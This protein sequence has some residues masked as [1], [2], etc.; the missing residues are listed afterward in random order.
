M[1]E[2][3]LFWSAGK[4]KP[5]SPM[6]I[7]IS[8][9]LQSLALGIMILIP[10]VYTEALPA[11]RIFSVLMTP[12]P[13]PPKQPIA[14]ASRELRVAIRPVPPRQ[15]MRQ[16]TVMPEHA[17][18]LH[19][20]LHPPIV[21][22]NVTDQVDWGSDVPA[23]SLSG[24]IRVA[25][26]PPP[27]PPAPQRIQVGGQVAAA[28][29]IYHPSPAYPAL[30]GRVRVQGTVRLQAVISKDGTIENLTVLSGH[31]LLI[32]AALDAVRQWRYQPTLLNGVPVEVETTIEIN[33]TLGG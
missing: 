18:I 13:R 23:T 16:P 22:S 5:R 26:P 20:E 17:A 15:D 10:L 3:S 1:F 7:A 33:F 21:T 30:A 32:P 27:P 14:A 8:F 19:E 24:A 28:K 4:L 2:D 12:P 6:T 11:R 9:L 29:L 25:P 31:P